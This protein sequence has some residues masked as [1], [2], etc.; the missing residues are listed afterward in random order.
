[1]VF[2]V[3]T[4]VFPFLDDDGKIPTETI[5]VKKLLLAK[6]QSL[7]QGVEHEAAFLVIYDES[8]V[9]NMQNIEMDKWAV[10]QNW[11]EKGHLKMAF[12]P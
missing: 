7:E 1:M 12:P 4:W 11:F 10:L 6:H 2:R 3:L 5:S 9:G 8:I